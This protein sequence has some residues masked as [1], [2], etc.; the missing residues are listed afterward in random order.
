MME[1]QQ[2]LGIG[3]ASD[4]SEIV[5]R[6]STHLN[7]SLS[8]RAS[9]KL[10]GLVCAYRLLDVLALMEGRLPNVLHSMRD[11]FAGKMIYVG[12]PLINFQKIEYITGHGQTRGMANVV[13]R[14]SCD[15]AK[16]TSAYPKSTFK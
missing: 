14:F 12:I 6:P 8:A 4:I 1:M 9:S 10:C 5:R 13:D 15:H 3:T 2:L 7:P 11:P 16:S